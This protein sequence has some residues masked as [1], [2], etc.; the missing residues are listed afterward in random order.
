MRGSAGGHELS[1][2]L[3]KIETAIFRHKT[4]TFDYFTM[5]R[6][7]VASRK[8]DPYHLLF[9]GGQFYLLGRD[10]L[11]KDVRTFR[12]SRIQGK[13]AYATKAEHDFKA[14]AEFDP[15]GFAN[16]AVWQYGER[17]GTARVWIS[18]RIAWQVE[19]HFGR[20]GEIEPA[21]GGIVFE[22]PY[23]NTRQLAAWVLSL[24]EYARVEGPPELVEAVRGRLA[25]LAERH[26][27]EI[28]LWSSS[29]P[30]TGQSAG[31]ALARAHLCSG[32]NL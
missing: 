8:V 1:Q 32:G 19:R 17:I 22:T 24:A 31:A 3:A 26:E 23:A 11:R 6:G 16:S 27:R 14:T 9:R 4:I 7:E 2:R 13:V 15:R 30:P 20:F 5:E 25:L 10:H 28:S 21:E 18:D 29:R 12:L